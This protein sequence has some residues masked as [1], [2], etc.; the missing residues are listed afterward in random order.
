MFYNVSMTPEQIK[1]VVSSIE[2]PTD[3]LNLLNKVKKE[4]YGAECH[5]FSLQH[6]NYYS[7]PS[8]AIK[9]YAHFKI[10]K[11]S[12][13]FREIAAPTK[14]LKSMLTCLNFVFKS[15]YR[16]SVV[17]KG[18]LPGMSV[19]DNAKPHVGMLYVFNTDLKDFFPCINLGRVWTVLQ[20]PQYGFSKDIA[21][22]IAGLCCMKVKDETKSDEEMTVYKYV[23]PQGAPTS[24]ILTNMVCQ[25]LDRRL[26][27]IARRF[28][29]HCTRYADDISFSGMYNVFQKDSTFRNELKRVITEQGFEVNVAKIRLQKKG[30]RQEVTG[31]TINTKVNVSR[32]YIRDIQSILY[33]W[34]RYGREVAYVRFARFYH[35]R[36][37][38]IKTSTQNIMERVILG[39]LMYLRMV[40]GE[41]DKVYMRLF[42]RFI[43]LRIP[44]ATDS[45]NYQYDLA[46]KISSFEKA[47]ETE[48]LFKI[49]K[50][51]EESDS[52]QRVYA[53]TRLN[54]QNEYVMISKNCASPVADA[55]LSDNQ[56][57]ISILKN[58]FYIVNCSN[59]VKTFWMIM[60]SNPKDYLKVQ[61]LM[62][63]EKR[64]YDDRPT[65]DAQYPVEI[66][67]TD[68]QSLK[69][70]NI[71]SE[72]VNSNFD[73]N[74]LDKWDRTN[75]S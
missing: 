1:Y 23:L 31:L 37:P 29:L 65:V 51:S 30:V 64:V 15:L 48:V 58:K 25:K 26:Q 59:K 52:L 68:G 8:R 14:D 33:I 41:N 49:K 24:P 19:V 4:I 35:A 66:E 34:E 17:A 44:S 6:L 63:N 10:P 22:L 72:L 56:E 12:G 57:E 71:L 9:A 75:S 67:K 54:N 62:S 53:I 7:S 70:N 11:K 50:I 16:P 74:I 2:S 55:L 28:N 21:K 32:K 69:I 36:Q 73:L 60:K 13:G 38:D 27:G 61:Q 3:L 45:S 40:K 20:L 43:A 18:F 47:F 46:Y 42:Y 5:P 39:K